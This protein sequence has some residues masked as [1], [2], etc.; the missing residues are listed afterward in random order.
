MCC[1]SLNEDFFAADVDAELYNLH[2]DIFAP[3]LAC[4][5]YTGRTPRRKIESVL[6]KLPCPASKAENA[7]RRPYSR[8]AL[9][10]YLVAPCAQRFSHKNL[11][12]A[13]Q[14]GH[15]ARFALVALHL[16]IGTGIKELQNQGPIYHL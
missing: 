4:N 8:S 9:P 6:L 5:K 3:R 2:F 15:E 11:N 7:L 14:Q 16:P 12:T 10:R 13:H 1:C